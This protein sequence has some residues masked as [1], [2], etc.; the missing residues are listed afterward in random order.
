MSLRQVF[1]IAGLCV[2]GVWDTIASAAGPY[3]L[4]HGRQVVLNRGIQIQGEVVFSS[5]PTSTDVSLW[6]NSNFTGLWFQHPV[7]DTARTL[8]AMPAGTQWSQFYNASYDS[9]SKYLQPNQLPYLNNFTSIQYEDEGGSDPANPTIL[10]DMTATY[11]DWNT[12]YPN[13]LAYAN[14]GVYQQAFSDATALTNYVQAAKPDMVCFD[15]YPSNWVGNPFATDDSHVQDR[16]G[17]YSAM[18]RY[19]T[20]ALAGYTTTSGG[21]SGPIPYAQ[22]LNLFRDSYSA[23]LYPEA[24]YRLEQNASWAFGYSYLVG[25]HYNDLGDGGDAPRMFDASGA[26]T[27][28]YYYVK[29]ANRQSRNLSPALARLVSTDIRMIPATYGTHKQHGTWG[30]L[31]DDNLALP[32]G[33]HAWSQG[34]Q[35]TGGYT[36]YI[37]G[38]APRGSD[39]GVSH[40]HSDVLIGYFAPLLASNPNC[41]FVD[42]LNFMIVNGGAGDGDIM[43]ASDLAETYHITF[44]FLTSGFNSLAR[45]S[46]TTGK[47]ELVTLTH[48]SG[49]QYSLDLTLDGGTGDLFRFWNSGDPLPT[50]PEPGMFTLLFTGLFYTIV[51]RAIRTQSSRRRYDEANIP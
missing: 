2:L 27:A 48:G 23:P 15:W 39:D 20:V 7:Q 37:T 18:Q 31:V 43:A 28:D 26:P 21:N 35:S 34:G 33:I 38:I 29:E 46:R 44:D 6:T 11:L 24:Y 40:I 25:Y 19:R 47:V 49:S 36:D 16:N 13:A 8:S 3:T 30:A 22:W 41:T 4:S 50:I 17:W 14:F 1:T 5:T 45:L 32:D 42:G 51:Y 9:R 10:A 12:R